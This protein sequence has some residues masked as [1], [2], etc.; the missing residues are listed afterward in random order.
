MMIERQ[1]LRRQTLHAATVFIP[2]LYLYFPDI[3]SL[4]GTQW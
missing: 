1:E 4:R 3:G 2:L